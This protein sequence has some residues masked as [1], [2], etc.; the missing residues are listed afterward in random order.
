[1]DRIME[2]TVIVQ[3]EVEDYAKGGWWQAFSYPISDHARQHYAVLVI[4]NYPREEPVTVVVAA[5][6]VDDLVVID[7]DIT[8]R[9]L[10]NELERAG[11]PRDKIICAYSGEQI[12]TKEA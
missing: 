10:V 11:I 9:P 3:R 1:M 8:D 2:L 12:P 7:E 4:P 6:I 5:R